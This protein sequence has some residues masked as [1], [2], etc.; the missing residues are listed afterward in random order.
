MESVPKDCYFSELFCRIPQPT[1]LIF[2][3]LLLT[4]AYSVKVPLTQAQLEEQS[5]ALIRTSDGSDVRVK[6]YT[7]KRAELSGDNGHHP[8]PGIQKRVTAYVDASGQVLRQNGFLILGD[9]STE[10]ADFQ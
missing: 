7:V 2:L 9:C 10:R 3:C 1:L 5:S 6:Y 8:L 4:P